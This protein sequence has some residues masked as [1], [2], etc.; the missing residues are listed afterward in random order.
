MAIP[1]THVGVPTSF[2]HLARSQ[3]E[4]K[5][6]ADC[7]AQRDLVV[8]VKDLRQLSHP[9]GIRRPFRRVVSVLGGGRAGYG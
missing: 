5:R 1:S 9:T 8:T 6:D 7:E 2:P 4:V 3:S